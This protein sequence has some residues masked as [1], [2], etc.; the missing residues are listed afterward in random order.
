MTTPYMQGVIASQAGVICL[1]VDKCHVKYNSV[2]FF[3][4]I[5]SADRHCPYSEEVKVI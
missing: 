4:N 3:G 2:K 1:D 5:L